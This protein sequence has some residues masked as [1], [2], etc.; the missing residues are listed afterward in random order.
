MPKGKTG[1]GAPVLSKFASR[2]SPTP[3]QLHQESNLRRLFLYD[4]RPIIVRFFRKHVPNA[5]K[6]RE[7]T[8]SLGSLN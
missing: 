4:K 7:A 8:S 1:R 3:P 6:I 5:P 2:S